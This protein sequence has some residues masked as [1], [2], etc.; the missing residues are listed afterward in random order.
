MHK[1]LVVDDEAYIATM[2]EEQLT[3]M[4]YDVVGT[5][6]SG[7]K[8]VEM[9]RKLRPELVLMDIV[10][11][12]MLD[13]IDASQIIKQELDIPIVF[14]TAYADDKFIE[15]AKNIEPLG[16]IVKPFQKRELKAVIEVALVKKAVE[17][18]KPQKTLKEK[19]AEKKDK[20]G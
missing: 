12:G 1:I 15:R 16:Y 10:M 2:V 3:S 7:Q 13:G 4:G 19:R 9:S 20:K 8:S 5:T 14:L 18:K 6:S 17:K 11:P